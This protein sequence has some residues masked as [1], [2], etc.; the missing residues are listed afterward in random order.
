MKRNATL[1]IFVFFLTQF[2]FSQNERLIQ[3]KIIV[4]D[5]T[6]MGVHVINLV[7]EKESI[8]DSKGNFTILAKLDDVLVFSAEHLDYQ[9]KIV[10]EQDYNSLSLTMEMTSKVNKLEEVEIVKLDAVALGIL[11]KPAKEYT[12]AERRLYSASTGPVDILL[13]MLSGRK[14]ML[15]D[16]LKTEKKESLLEGLD[17]LYDDAFYKNR[18]KIDNIKGFHYFLAENS[19]FGEVLKSKNKQLITFMII[20]QAE[21]YNLLSANEQK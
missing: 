10:E 5:A 17:G 6:P 16:D 18:L 7:N 14:K 13:N 15:E 11:D 1:L 12:P 20:E 4:R 19:K 3:G 8:S 2:I 21:Q 9:R